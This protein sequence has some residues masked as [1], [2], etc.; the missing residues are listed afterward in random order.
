MAVVGA[1]ACRNLIARSN[2]VGGESDN[3]W[4]TEDETQHRAGFVLHDIAER[5]G[6]AVEV[7]DSSVIASRRPVTRKSSLRP[8]GARPH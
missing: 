8:H 6:A 3:A 2:A 5:D 1:Q 7:R 4:T